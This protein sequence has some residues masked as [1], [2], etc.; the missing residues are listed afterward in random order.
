[1]SHF[2]N[3]NEYCNETVEL[4]QKR[5]RASDTTNRDEISE[6]V[7]RSQLEMNKTKEA[8]CESSKKGRHLSPYHVK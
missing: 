6:V 1:M 7:M 8:K 5:R 3:D 2:Q 4:F